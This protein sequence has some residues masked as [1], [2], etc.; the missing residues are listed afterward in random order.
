MHL[1]VNSRSNNC[2]TIN[3][4]L[5][6]YVSKSANFLEFLAF[7]ILHLNIYLDFSIIEAV[8][9]KVIKNNTI[10]PL[11][12]V[13]NFYNVFHRINLV[14]P[15]VLIHLVAHFQIKTNLNNF[16]LKSNLYLIFFLSKLQTDS[17]YMKLY[18]SRANNY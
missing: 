1:L 3:C 11:K 4:W 7:H 2:Q 8:N 13:L 18:N 12:F 15:Y 6:K 14:H 16:I 5:P 9:Y 17:I 10:T